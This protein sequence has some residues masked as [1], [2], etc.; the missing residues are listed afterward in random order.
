MVDTRSEVKAALGP[1]VRL[2]RAFPATVRWAKERVRRSR[3]DSPVPH[4]VPLLV[5]R[6]CSSC[7]VIQGVTSPVHRFSPQGF[8]RRQLNIGKDD[9]RLDARGESRVVD[10]T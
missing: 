1:G 7:G 3:C 5:P 8:G 4:F 9:G 10:G 6:V 2:R